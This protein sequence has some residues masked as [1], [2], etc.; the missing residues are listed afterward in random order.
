[1]EPTIRHLTFD[2]AGEPYE[3]AGFW[4]A[5]L[6]RSIS[7]TDEPGDE[8]VLVE[9]PDEGPG[10]L[11]VRAEERGA[12]RS[13]IHLDLQPTDRTRAEE[14]ARALDLGARL[15]ADRTTENGRG[16]VV[17]ADPEGNEFCVEGG[18]RDRA[19]G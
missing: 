13:G 2:C 8:E 19:G 16:W 17:L 5:L 3:L 6:G 15:V 12:V 9:A 14:V 1:M 10:L 7:S 4:A 18:A 11:F